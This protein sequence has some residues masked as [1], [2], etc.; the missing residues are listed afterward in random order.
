MRKTFQEI[1]KQ[2][3][4][5]LCTLMG[6][7]F[8]IEIANDAYLQIVDKR[9]EEIT[10]RPIFDVHPELREALE[11]ILRKVFETGQTHADTEF[12]VAFN[13]YGRSDYA[14]F[15][16]IYQPLRNDAGE[17]VGIVVIIAEVTELVVARYRL[18][19]RENT[20]RKMVMDSPVA[21]AIM[22]GP[23]LIIEMANNSM[24]KKFWRR[25]QEEVEGKP[26]LDVFPELEGQEFPA[27]I[28]RVMESGELYKAR[29]AE[30]YIDAA[31][32]RQVFY[33]D[34][35]NAPLISD[36]ADKVTGVMLSIYDV[37]ETVLANR[38]AREAEERLRL[39]IEATRLGNY[40]V[41]L[42]NESMHYSRGFLEIFGLEP[43]S[44]PNR[45]DLVAKIHPEDLRSREEAHA[46]A[47]KTG[48][49]DYEFRVFPSERELR[50]VRARGTVLFDKSGRP[51][52]L[53]GTILDVT[54]EK[55]MVIAL[56]NSEQKFRLLADI[57]PA[58]VWM[59]DAE[60]HLNYFNR[61]VY[62][63]TGLTE[64]DL[65][66]KGWLG[67]VHPD[68]RAENL[69]E[70]MESIRT[71]EPFL[72]EH[73][74]RRRDGVYRWQLS[75][76]VPQYN[77]MGEIEMW[78]GSSTDIHEH[79]IF[80]DELEKQVQE[81][82]QELINSN[83]ALVKSNTELAQ[84]AY[85]AS[86]DLQEPLRKI[87]TFA[88]L[89]ADLEK[90]R[91]SERGLEIIQRLRSTA[92]RMQQLVVDLLSY[93]RMTKM[94]NHFAATDLPY[95]VNS[96]L[97]QMEDAIAQR[98]LKVSVDPLPTVW[99]IPFQMEQLFTNLISNSIKFS[100]TSKSPELWIRY[101]LLPAGSREVEELRPELS[102]HRIQVIDNG[103]GFDNQYNEKIF[104]VF[105][106]LHSK[107]TFAGTGIGLAICKK[108]VE[109]HQG[110]ITANGQVGEGATFTIYLPLFSE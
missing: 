91:L 42:T 5:G 72:F 37:T 75:R 53:A 45:E 67:V 28:R 47:L 100:D 62:E 83:D 32:G 90:S 3:P 43:D 52:K 96:I 76:A 54:E 22:R 94:E 24:L 103:I 2:A 46:K 105:Q 86:H 77:D 41:D 66:E 61:S 48:D 56:R 63:Y 59:S 16:V 19:E 109:N 23:E 104:Q 70:W 1:A 110:H 14:Y 79:K 12:R 13:R 17:V 9:G 29:E 102:Y 49:L 57:L 26:L 107:E 93:S 8:T 11:P 88:S 4:V 58:M 60:G 101:A 55:L 51:V 89:V 10:G 30:M 65:T 74:F 108:I 80:T 7:Q 81:R 95:L 34:L 33:V 44:S 92:E 18:E 50:W 106:R 40:E 69:R 71:G 36:Q 15:N 99:A 39:A 20:F 97:Q 6:A 38:K 21:M 98:H 82:T 78:V 64:T 84:F 35:E 85:V 68:D 25:T 87:Q 27:L 31:D 73:R